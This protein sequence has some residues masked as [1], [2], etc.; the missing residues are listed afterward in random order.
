MTGKVLMDGPEVALK[1]ELLLFEYGTCPD[2]EQAAML[3][4]HR[5][6]LQPYLEPGRGWLKL[7]FEN[8]E[9]CIRAADRVGVLPFSVDGKSHL[10]LIAP[11]GCQQDQNLGLL[12]FLELLAFDDDGPPPDKLFGL[13]GKLGPH[14]FLLFLA[15]HYAA[16]LNE[17]CRRDFRSFYRAEEDEVRGF[18]RGRLHLTGYARLALR[19]KQHIL[20]CRWDE[21][22]VDNWDNRILW[23]VVRRLQNAAAALG[24]QASQMVAKPFRLLLGWFGP[25]AEV[26]ITSADF[27]RTRLGRT[28]RYYRSALVWARLLLQGSNLPGAGGQVPPLVLDAPI[29]FEKF[30]EVVAKAALP[31]ESWCFER[32]RELPFL[33]G[34]QKQYRKPDILL[35]G[36]DELCAVGDTKYKDVLDRSNDQPL[37]TAEEVLE[38][39]IQPTDWNQLYV[40]MRLKGASSG[41][42]VVPF[43]NAAVD[44]APATFLENFQF[45]KSP[46][47]GGRPVRAAVIGLNLLKPLGDVKQMAATKLSTWLSGMRKEARIELRSSR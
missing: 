43:W 7:D 20:P 2:K 17:L 26:P 41:F 4:K 10:L 25:V 44:S 42:F 23:A 31:D 5:Q 46:C 3:Y 35:V 14:Q 30:A 15:R 13:D 18:I 28:S 24:P 1:P 21:F 34:Q 38:A 45:E 32:Q 6:D 33:N 39:S 19:G 29:A 16:L 11:K 9:P 47:N 22:T 8:G 36:P 40:Y 12:R 37:G 27:H